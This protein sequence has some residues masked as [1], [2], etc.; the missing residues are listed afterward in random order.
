MFGGQLFKYLLIVQAVG[1]TSQIVGHGVFE[2]RAPALLT[3]LLFAYIAPFFWTF[4]VLNKLFG[5]RQDDV[6]ACAAVV[7]AD[8][9]FYRQ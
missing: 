5:Y 8:I 3:N 4:E 9:A 2:R 1:W 6:D 7:E